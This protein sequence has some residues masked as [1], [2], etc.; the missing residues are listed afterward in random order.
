MKKL[1]FICVLFAVIIGVGWAIQVFF[2]SKTTKVEDFGDSNYIVEGNNFLNI[3]RYDEAKQLFL[4]ALKND[5]KNVKAEWG[6]KKAAAKELSTL[7]G[8]KLAVD[9]LYKKDPN[10]A[11]VNLFLGEFYLANKEYEKARPYFE[12]AM[13]QNPKLAE[14]HFDLALLHDQQ[15]D[16]NAAKSELSLAIDIVPTAK[17]RNELGHAYIKQK[18]LD[19]ATAEY[20]KISEY[21]ASA[22]DVAEIYLQRDRL[23]IALIRQLQAVEWLNNDS[24]MAKP[25]NKDSWS[26]KISDEK[27]IKLSK[28]HEKKAFAY[29]CLSFTLYLLENTE[30]ADRNFQTMLNLDVSRQKDINAVMSARLDALVQEKNSLTIKVESFKSKYLITSR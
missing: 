7:N 6:L 21:P 20:E 29:L 8:F 16:I 9:E 22:L 15:G 13:T 30:E 24:V 11:H 3:G 28:L 10:D 4:E 5:P 14:A 19:A 25:E 23:D 26:F 27:T 17:Y 12:Q 2:H 1:G 18:H